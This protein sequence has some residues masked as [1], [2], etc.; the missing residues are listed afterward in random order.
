M[1][2]GFVGDDLRDTNLRLYADADF[3]GCK[4]TMRSTSGVFACAHGASTM[5]PLAARCIKQTCVSHSTP[6]AEIVAGN[7]ALNVI[8]LPFLDALD[9]LAGYRY[10]LDFRGDNQTMI[11]VCTT[12]KNPTTITLSRTHGVC[13]AWLHE[14]FTNGPE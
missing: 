12:G 9:V 13:V 7:A 5:Y 2:V 8:G 6:E 4:A 3:V 1:L 14:T 10:P 11:S